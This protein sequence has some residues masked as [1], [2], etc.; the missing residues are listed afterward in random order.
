MTRL[1]LRVGV[2]K[3]KWGWEGAVLLDGE[4]VMLTGNEPNEHLAYKA[5]RQWQADLEADIR[6]EPHREVHV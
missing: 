5:A 6:G 2:R 1:R 4:V 3:T